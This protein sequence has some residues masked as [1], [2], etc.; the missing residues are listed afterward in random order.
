MKKGVLLIAGLLALGML[1][2]CGNKKQDIETTVNE[3]N[4]VSSESNIALN[5][6][7]NDSSTEEKANDVVQDNTPVSIDEPNE[8]EEKLEPKNETIPN[9]SIAVF[10]KYEQKT[11][12]DG[13]EPIEWIV[14]EDKGEQVL[15]MSRFILD[16]CFYGRDNEDYSWE[17]SAVREFLNSAFF[18]KAFS[19]EEQEQIVNTEVTDTFGTTTDKVFLLSK[20]E[21]LSY[22]PFDSD[23]QY[24]A[25][26]TTEYAREK[27]LYYVTEDEITVS[28]EEKDYLYYGQWHLRDVYSAEDENYTTSRVTCVGTVTDGVEPNAQEEGVRPAIWVKKDAIKDFISFEEAM[29]DDGEDTN[30]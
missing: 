17:N 26:K 27:D 24:L 15:L 3:S 22:Y 10:G 5:E 1:G 11:D 8:S 6:K 28:P 4:I 13:D 14:V 21:V 25:A 23:K 12:I 30:K 16:S 29:A 18:S 2:A 9:N 19:E 20:R 7:E